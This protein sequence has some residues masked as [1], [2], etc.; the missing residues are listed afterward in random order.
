MRLIFL[1]LCL[2]SIDVYSANQK[3][4]AGEWSHVVKG[5]DTEDSR[6][7]ELTKR[8]KLYCR[9]ESFGWSE[10]YGDGHV[11]LQT[12]TWVLKTDKL[13]LEFTLSYDKSDV[14]TEE[15]VVSEINKDSIVLI[16]QSG[17]IEIWNRKAEVH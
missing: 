6:V 14:M 10:G 4:I 13:H 3:K 9:V 12:G 1:F 15:F 17:E 5:E 8:G 2:L 11:F 7:C 16:N